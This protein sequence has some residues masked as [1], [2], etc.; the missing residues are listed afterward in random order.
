MTRK[1]APECRRLIYRHTRGAWAGIDQIV[2]VVTA[3]HFIYLTVREARSHQGPVPD[4]LSEVPMMPDGRES[5]ALRMKTT[6][7]YVLYQEE[8]VEGHA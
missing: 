2:G 1:K 6:N 4:V 3:N 8:L 5:R 7:R